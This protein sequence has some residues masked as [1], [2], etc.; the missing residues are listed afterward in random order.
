MKLKSSQYGKGR[1]RVVK[2]IREGEMHTVKELDV[3]AMMSGDFETS[4]TESDNSKVVPTDTI[5][6]TINVLAKDH[7]GHDSERFAL[8]LAKHFVGKYPQIHQATVEV[9]ER[10][11]QRIGGH[12]HS[13]TAPGSPSPLCRA[14]A[15][16]GG[17]TLESGV[18]D[19]LILKST[20]SGFEG[21]PKCEFTTL[22]ETKDRIFATSCT[23]TWKWSAHPT[24]FANANLA[25]ISAMVQPFCENYSASVQ[26]TMF[27]MGSAALAAVPEISEIHLAMP[28][29]HCLLVNFTPFGLENKNEV[30]TATDEPHGQIEATITR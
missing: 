28:N 19:W 25:I 16:A 11:W 6:N 29:K 24:S 9:K 5:K 18:S 8:T 1:V 7:L 20:E 3:K 26:G 13:F 17:E 12:P 14:T 4:Y 10:V 22:P 23:A 30:F 27:E 21:Y 15:T 2:I